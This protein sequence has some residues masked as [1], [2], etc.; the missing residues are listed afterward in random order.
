MKQSKRKWS[1]YYDAVANR[2][3]RPTLLKALDFYET[4]ISSLPG[5]AVD[6]GCGTGRDTLELLRRGWQVL[7]IDRETEAVERTRLNAPAALQPQLKTRVARFEKLMLPPVQ[8][9]N[10]SF[11]L[12]FC[13]PRHFGLFWQ[14]IVGAL[15]SGGLFA[16]HLFGDRD[17]WAQ[18]DGMTFHTRHQVEQRLDEFEVVQL[19]EVEEDGSTARKKPKHWHFFAIVARKR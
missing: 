19:D 8:L 10:G 13:Q 6:L 16:G 18:A 15:D 4:E 11:S 5:K 12:P 3:P 1:D 9:I 7:A 14:T 2:P 17:G